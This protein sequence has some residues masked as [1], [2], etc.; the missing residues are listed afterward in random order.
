MMKF[1]KMAKNARKIEEF[2]CFCT[3][4]PAELNFEKGCEVSAVLHHGSYIRFGCLQFVFSITNYE[5]DHDR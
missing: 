4:T 3:S 5:N 1:K 2:S